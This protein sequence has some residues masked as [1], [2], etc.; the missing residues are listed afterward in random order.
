MGYP[1]LAAGC[2]EALE[3]LRA[4]LG[5]GLSPILSVHVTPLPVRDALTP[6]WHPDAA[7][8]AMLGQKL[9]SPAKGS[10]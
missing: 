2:V 5:T 4:P 6:V 10:K 3:Q 8:L 7:V 9:L 1:A